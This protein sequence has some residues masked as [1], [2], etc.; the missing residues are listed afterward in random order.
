MEP[1]RRA[2]VAGRWYPAEPARLAADVDHYLAT[3]PVDAMPD[4]RALVAPHAGLMYSGPVAAFAYRAARQTRYTTVVL[5][6]PSHFVPFRG[7][8]VWPRGAWQ[9]PFGHVGVDEPLATAIASA[10]PIEVIER[11]DAHGREHSLEM[12]LPFVAHLWPTA[13]IVPLVMG[14]QTRATAFAVGEAIAAAVASRRASVTGHASAPKLDSEPAE[15]DRPR[16]GDVLLVASSDLSH[17]EDA[18]TAAALDD[19]VIRH[20]A[21][22]DPEGLMTA[23]EREPR[24]ACG[25]GPIVAV[26]QAAGLL[27]AAHARPLHYADSGDVSGDKSS[28][29]G[30]LAAAIW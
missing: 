9:T 20:V 19:V 2:A 10:A 24:H 27:A 11:P 3:A 22:M 21:A 29:V 15:S 5:I 26:L 25:G 4:V 17:Y 13:Q 30:Y 12:Q 7:V 18:N 1:L 28:V 14:H 23:L 6:G 16:P 8:S